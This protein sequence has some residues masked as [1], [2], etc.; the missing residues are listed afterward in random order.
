M[1]QCLT[2]RS[3]HT[4]VVSFSLEM[5]EYLKKK[6]NVLV[7]EEGQFDLV[8]NQNDSTKTIAKNIIF[9][10]RIRKEK[11]SKMIAKCK[12]IFVNFFLDF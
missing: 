10:L 8:V 12:N 6:K 7:A 1:L 2:N 3:N 4:K 5:S 9:F 11:I